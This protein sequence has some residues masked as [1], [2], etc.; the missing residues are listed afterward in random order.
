MKCTLV[1]KFFFFLLTGV[2]LTARIGAVEAA[3]TP[4]SLAQ[5]AEMIAKDQRLVG[6]VGAQAKREGVITN[7]PEL[8]IYYRDFSPA[9][10]LSGY[11]ETLPRELDLIVSN[12]RIERS[13]VRLDRL[14]ERTFDA[15]GAVPTLTDLPAAALYA[16]I[17]QDS[18]CIGCR[19]VQE[20]L[21]AWAMAQPFNLVLISVD[22]D[23]SLNR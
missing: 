1:T 9:Y 20:T 18:D 22:V 23:L 19:Q 5:Q 8:F 3:I 14:L 7:T 2:V 11:R 16:V 6:N 17:Y 13:M 15:N 10:H 4:I 21:S 12:H